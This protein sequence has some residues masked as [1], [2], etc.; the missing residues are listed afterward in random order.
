MA[1]AGLITATVFVVFF[2]VFELWGTITKKDWVLIASYG[3]RICFLLDLI[4]ITMILHLSGILS[5]YTIVKSLQKP[6]MNSSY[7]YL[8]EVC[9]Q[10]LPNKFFSFI[11]HF[12][13][14][15]VSPYECPGLWWHRPG[16]SLAEKNKVA[17]N[18]KNYRCF[19]FY[20]DR[21]LDFLNPPSPLV[22]WCRFLLDPP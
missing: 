4:C 1:I 13:Q 10:N 20:V 6:I 7:I 11:F 17:Q 22:D 14:L 16:H 2:F 5:R 19:P 8:L 15:W 9:T 12:E 18:E 3:F 21:F